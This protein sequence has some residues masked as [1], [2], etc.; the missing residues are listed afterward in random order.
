MFFN[1][2]T[3]SSNFKFHK[4]NPNSST[5]NLSAPLLCCFRINMKK[6]ILKLAIL[7]KTDD[8]DTPSSKN[9][10]MGQSTEMPFV[11]CTISF[12]RLSRGG[13]ICS[14][15]LT[16]F[17]LIS[18]V[19]QLSNLIKISL[20]N[21]SKSHPHSR[22]VVYYILSPPQHVIWSDHSDSLRWIINN[23]KNVLLWCGSIS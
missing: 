13:G 9:K 1:W 6:K 10:M 22:I 5:D 2:N 16:Y 3:T 17:F 12:L 4:S 7:F 18:L 19:K 21:L 11:C 15:R 23:T 20:K 8:L 14:S